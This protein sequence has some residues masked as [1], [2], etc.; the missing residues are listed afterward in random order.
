MRAAFV[1]LHFALAQYFCWWWISRSFSPP[2]GWV[3]SKELLVRNKLAAGRPQ[4]L[5]SG[6]NRREK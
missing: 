3:I 6:E 5:A 1:A 2:A 4:D